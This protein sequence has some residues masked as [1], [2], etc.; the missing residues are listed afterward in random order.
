MEIGN[1]IIGITGII[2]GIFAG[3]CFRKWK[4][5]N[6]NNRTSRL[7]KMSLENDFEV[8]QM[9]NELLTENIELKKSLSCRQPATSI[10]SDNLID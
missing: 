1:L 2:F 10:L 3:F 5:R 9:L 7:E 4:I 6:S 8:L